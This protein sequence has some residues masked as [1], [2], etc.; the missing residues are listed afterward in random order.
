MLLTSPRREALRQLLD[1]CD[2]TTLPRP[3]DVKITV[4]VDPQ[5]FL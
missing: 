5:D 1:A 2:P 3:A 4:D